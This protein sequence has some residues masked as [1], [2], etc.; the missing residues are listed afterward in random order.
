MVLV[1]QSLESFFF[2]SEGDVGHFPVS[3]RFHLAE[4]FQTVVLEVQ[5]LESFFF[6]SEGDVR[7][8]PV[9]QRFH[10]AE[11]QSFP[12][13]AAFPP[14]GGFSDS[15]AGDPRGSGGPVLSLFRTVST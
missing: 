8:F 7:H 4:G 9:S 1:V 2:D 10:L 14:S 3:Q 13:F 12:C 15:G 11:V 5:S 6:D